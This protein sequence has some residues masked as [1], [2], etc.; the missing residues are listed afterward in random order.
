MNNVGR[1]RFAVNIN[2]WNENKNYEFE[3]G[4]SLVSECEAERIKKYYQKKDSKSSLIGRLLLN[5]MAQY[6]LQLRCS[7]ILWLRSDTKKPYISPKTL[8]KLPQKFDNFS[9]NISHSGYWVVAASELD[10]PIGIDVTDFGIRPNCKVDFD[11]EAEE[12]INVYFPTVRK[13]IDGFNGIF[14]PSE[15]IYMKSLRSECSEDQLLEFS[16]IWTVKESY[17]KTHGVGL[18]LDISNISCDF[19]LFNRNELK[20]LPK[21]I[22]GVNIKIKTGEDEGNDWKF[23]QFKLDRNHVVTVSLDATG[24]T[25]PPCFYPLPL[26]VLT[27][28]RIISYL[29]SVR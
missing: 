6:T 26:E 29:E 2:E 4:L 22:E 20:T 14:S 21:L 17:A 8:E 24:S 27:P 25:L 12:D 11:A 7:D 16:R 28:S 13:F 5:L 19:N 18:G 1:Y 15:Q 9:Y 3:R 10:I 23:E